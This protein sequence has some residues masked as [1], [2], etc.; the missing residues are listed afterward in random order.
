MMQNKRTFLVV[1]DRLLKGAKHVIEG[2]T[3]K[4]IFYASHA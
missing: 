2:K 3:L 1:V 4:K